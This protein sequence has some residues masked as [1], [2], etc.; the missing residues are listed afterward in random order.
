MKTDY[1]QLQE[2]M[3]IYAHAIDTKDYPGVDACFTPDA[4]T[5]Y[6][7]HSNH[8]KGV[9]AIGAHMRSSLAPL[10]ATQHVFMNF[11]VNVDGDTAKFSADIIAQHV[12]KGENYMAGGKYYV[13]AKRVGGQWKIHRVNAGSHWGMGNKGM[14]PKADT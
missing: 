11:I 8:L 7:G 9:E 1:N 5:V 10:D 4:E 2:L 14:L 12:K 13:D 6:A 3:A